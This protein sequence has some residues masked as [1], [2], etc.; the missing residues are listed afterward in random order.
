MLP[1]ASTA[2]TSGGAEATAAHCQE[3]LE[4]GWP[5]GRSGWEAGMA[6]RVQTEQGKLG[7]ILR[8]IGDFKEG[9]K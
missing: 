5:S 9:E 4:R 8:A 6:R 2:W 3:Q 7:L 1:A